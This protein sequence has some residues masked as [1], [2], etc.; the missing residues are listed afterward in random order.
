[1]E[2]WSSERIRGDKVIR[3][4][5]GDGEVAGEWGLGHKAYPIEMGGESSMMADGA[6]N[7]TSTHRTAEDQRQQLL[8]F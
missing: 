1:L 7:T 4:A 5:N 3:S 6:K 2:Q 8:A